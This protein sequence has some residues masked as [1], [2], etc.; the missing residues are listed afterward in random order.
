MN[1]R[2]ST[3]ALLCAFLFLSCHSNPEEEV[4]VTVPYTF[5]VFSTSTGSLDD[6]GT[7]APND[8]EIKNLLVVDIKDDKV[9]QKIERAD[10]KSYNVT[11]PVKLNLSFGK[12]YVCFLASTT[13]WAEFDEQT[14]QISWN[15]ENPLYSVWSKVV[16][17][18]VKPGDKD[19]EQQVLI[20]RVVAF[21]I[22]T[23]N[24]KLPENLHSFRQTLQ[25]GSWTYDILHQ[26]GGV[27]SLIT[28]DV[29]VPSENI[30]KEKT[31]IGIYTFLPDG[32]CS[33]SSYTVTAYD[34]QQNVL[35]SHTFNDVPLVQNQYTNYVGNFFSVANTCGFQ[36]NKTWNTPNI[37]EY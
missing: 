26:T 33:A 29:I 19:S 6:L 4:T 13:P 28:R 25:G 7:R 1:F 22:T 14:F 9:Y 24:D 30:G 18:D 31:T 8:S 27:A 5:E 12:H 11:T 2:F 34:E 10:D 35:Q 17:I 16:E 21:V 20:E 36:I 32:A 23:I 15:S 37:I 3:C